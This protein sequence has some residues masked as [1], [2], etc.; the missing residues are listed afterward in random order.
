[1]AVVRATPGRRADAVHEVRLAELVAALSLASD[2]GVGQPMEHVLRGCLLAVGFARELGLPDA[3]LRDVYDVALLRRIGCMADSREASRLFGDELAARSGILSHGFTRRPQ[4]MAYAVGRIGA[5]RPPLERARTL[6]ATAVRLP[7]VWS[8]AARAHLEVAQRLAAGLGFG[9]SVVTALGQTYAHWDGGGQP[10]GLAGEGIAPAARIVAIAGDAEIFHRLDGLDAMA[11][12]IR[13]RAGRW[14]D[15]A[16]TR[17]FLAAAPALTAGLEGVTS[18]DAV[19][20]A[21]PSPSRRLSDGDMDAALTALADFVDLKSP[22]F[23]RHSRGV[24]E[25]AEAAARQ[26]GLPEADVRLV[27]RA[28]LVH[29]LGRAGVPNSIWEKPGALTEWEW[30]RVRL[31]T[32]YLERMLARVP[33]L[34]AAV[35]VAGL[36]HERL[37]GSGYHRAAAA[38]DLSLP[39]RVLQAADVCQALGEA[40]PHRPARTP[41]EAAD[42]LRREARA[43]RLDGAA[44]EAMLSAGA[45]RPR[46]RQWPAGLTTREVEVLRLLARGDTNKDIARTLYV[47]HRTV[48]HHL[49]HI[50][51]KL[52]V[53]TRAGATLFGMQHDLLAA[54]TDPV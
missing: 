10:R 49:Q 44:V 34:E 25:R 24:A 50:Y 51:R 26:L 3:E 5:G 14:Y 15:P 54:D 12:V 33:S 29:D 40:R 9:D 36:H 45:R 17:R 52:G 43:G 47:S 8:E 7:G 23:S 31:H 19:L 27:R 32:Y 39:A 28:G 46:R 22:Y 6:A 1:M 11:G 38:G 2:L 53:T 16:L 18:W 30:E 4:I 20:A 42:E 37:D 48:G 41:G 21:E 13:R 35:R